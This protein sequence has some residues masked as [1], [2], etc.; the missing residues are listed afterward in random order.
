MTAAATKDPGGWV[1]HAGGLLVPEAVAREQKHADVRRA[2]MLFEGSEDNRW[3]ESWLHPKTDPIELIGSYQPKM[4]DRS[5]SLARN[6]PWFQGIKIAWI[7]DVIGRGFKLQAKPFK[8]DVGEKLDKDL[9]KRLEYLWRRQIRGVDA[10]RRQSLTMLQRVC[11]SEYIETGEYFLVQRIVK[12]SWVTPL[13]MELFPSERLDP[14]YN[15]AR[16]FSMT[17]GRTV[18][19]ITHGIEFDRDGRR[20]AYHFDALDEWGRPTGLAAKE[21]I[22]AS[23]VTHRFMQL[24]AGQ[25]RGIPPLFSVILLLRDLDNAIEYELE[26]W[27]SSARMIGAIHH[28]GGG[29][30]PDDA[31]RDETDKRPI[32]RAAGVELFDLK[33]EEKLTLQA[34]VRPNDRLEP[35]VMFAAR[36]F[37]KSIGFSYEATTGDYSQVNFASGRLGSI[38]DRQTV[39]WHQGDIKHVD[40]APFYESFVFLCAQAEKLPGVDVVKFVSEPDRYTEHTFI[41]EGREHHDPGKDVIA[42]GLRWLL[43]LSTRAEECAALGKDWEE[44][45]E[46]LKRENDKYKELELPLVHVGGAQQATGRGNEGF[47]VDDGEDE[48]DDRKAD[49]TRRMVADLCRM[50]MEFDRSERSDHAAA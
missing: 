35:F 33:P 50:A 23:R 34:P 2:R 37:G 49:R 40:L 1:R 7:N 15:R 31:E 44:V 13:A 46:Q 38:S 30:F 21:P 18:N 6:A 27:Q 8:D 24:R 4:R 25:E 48:D 32:H 12:D 42:A 43:G 17:L 11:E 41:A 19:R 47:G 14:T 22:P 20:V 16:T 26:A 10:N 28:Q 3:T 45:A 9:A 5:R 36:T 39:R 29:V